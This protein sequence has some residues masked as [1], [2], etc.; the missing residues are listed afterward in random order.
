MAQSGTPVAVFALLLAGIACGDDP[1]GLPA[2][3]GP[4][5][6]PADDGGAQR[7]TVVQGEVTA[8]GYLRGADIVVSLESSRPLYSVLCATD[9]KLETRVGDSWQP[10]RNDAPGH[11]AYHDGYY[12]DDLYIPPTL[13]LGCDQQVCW[14]SRGVAGGGAAVETIAAGTRPPPPWVQSEHLA[15]PA[16]LFLTQPVSGPVRAELTYFTDA[17]CQSPLTV[18]VELDVPEDGV[19]CPVGTAGCA[20]SGPAGGW[21][22]TLETC[23]DGGFAFSDRSELVTDSRGCAALQTLYPTVENPDVAACMR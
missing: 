21:A 10:L 19:C 5:D 15:D 22:A 12:L 6:G 20:S 4:N 13:G 23:D 11:D 2:D 18:S 3:G 14:E 16:P 8:T 9:F 1:A 7:V 17:R